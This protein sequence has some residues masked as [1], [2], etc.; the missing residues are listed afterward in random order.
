MSKGMSLEDLRN[1]LEGDAQK[2][3]A[4][5]EEE[6][7]ALKNSLNAKES[8]IRHLR[9]EIESKDK[10][11]YYLFNRCRAL[12]RE[13]MCQ[14]CGIRYQ[15]AV[16]RHRYADPKTE[17]ITNAIVDG[18]INNLARDLLIERCEQIKE[19]YESEHPEVLTNASQE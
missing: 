17:K 15:C 14:F 3:L 10:Q 19:Q 9:G 8:Q 11:S 6:I 2:K 18:S 7:N 13:T 1:N 16:I 12:S 4:L 5:A